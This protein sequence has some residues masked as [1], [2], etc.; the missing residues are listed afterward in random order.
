MIP[1]GL[2]SAAAVRVGHAVGAHDRPRAS[3]AGWTAILL[4]VAFTA[5]AA[6]VFLLFPRALIGLFTTEPEVLALGSTL[7]LVGAAFQLFDGFQGVIDGSAARPRRYADTDDLESVGHW[8]FGLPV[9][10]TLCFA[11]RLWRRGTLDRPVDWVDPRRHRAVDRVDQRGETHPMINDCH[12][13]FFSPR[14]FEA[15]GAQVSEW[16]APV[17]P[18]ALADR[19]VAE[20][21]RHGVARAALIASVPGDETSV[22]AAVARHPVAIRGL[23]HARSDARRCAAQ[24]AARARQPASAASACSRRCIATR[25]HDERVAQIVEIAAPHSPGAAVF[26]HCGVLS[27]GVR[28]KLGLPSRVRHPLRQPARSARARAAVPARADHHSALRRRAAARGADGGGPLPERL[29]RHVEL[30]RVDPVYARAHAGAKCFA[31]PS[32]SSVPTRLLFGTDSSFFPRGWN[33][34]STTRSRRRSTRSGS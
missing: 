11:I 3:A 34:R 18:E 30:E 21:D 12:V 19:W 5:V 24:R 7:L 26:V 25:S 28:R 31:P 14:F 6:L 23:L 29:P 32:T 20:L 17:S 8:F 13:H 15:L 27:V 10:Y 33:R 9:G 2:S 4:A 16:D 22:A 1:L